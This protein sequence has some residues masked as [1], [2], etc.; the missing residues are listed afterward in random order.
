[1]SATAPRIQAIT[2]CEH[3]LFQY[4]QLWCLSIVEVT[5]WKWSFRVLSK[6]GSWRG[7]ASFIWPLPTRHV[8]LAEKW[9]RTA[10][11][12]GGLW[13]AGREKWELPQAAAA[14]I[15]LFLN[16]PQPKVLSTSSEQ[17]L[18][19]KVPLPFLLIP[20]EIPHAQPSNG[21][22]WVY[23]SGVAPMMYNHSPQHPLAWNNYHLFSGISGLATE[24][25]LHAAGLWA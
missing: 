22:D 8:P 20:G 1:M 5:S 14:R 13:V 11:W 18:S 17:S 7:N 25:L 15:T 23:W 3:P 10:W 16:Y 12:V 24:A 19:F 9:Q 21:S 6:S 2:Q 4:H